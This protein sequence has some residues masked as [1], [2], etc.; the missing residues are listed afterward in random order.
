MKKPKHKQ[1]ICQWR[2]TALILFT[3]I[4]VFEASMAQN[5]V[6]VEIDAT[7]KIVKKKPPFD[8]P[9]VIK[10]K[11]PSKDRS[12]EKI[13]LYESFVRN[14]EKTPLDRKG[15][16]GRNLPI[17]RFEEK[18][19]VLYIYVEPIGPNVYLELV[20]IH[21]FTGKNLEKLLTIN[22]AI[23]SGNAGRI[24]RAK[25]SFDNLVADLDDESTYDD[26]PISA[27]GAN[28]WTD[29]NFWQDYK[30]FYNAKLKSFYDKTS[31]HNYDTAR[32]NLDIARL[33]GLAKGAKNSNMTS[34]ALDQFSALTRDGK[35]LDLIKGTQSFD[36]SSYAKKIDEFDFAGRIN[37]L[38]NSID[39]LQSLIVFCEGYYLISNNV[40]RNTIKPIIDDLNAILKKMKANSVFLKTTQTAIV[41]EIHKENNLRFAEAFILDNQFADLATES[42]FRVIPDFGIANIW[43]NGNESNEAYQRFY[44]GIN[45][46]PRPVNKQIK[47]REYKDANLWRRWSFSLGV[48]TSSLPE[49]EFED[50]YKSVSL[51]AG[52]NFRVLR[53]LYI[54]SGTVLLRRKDPNPIITD[55]SVIMAPYV[56]VSFDV[57]I[58]KALSSITGKFL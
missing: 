30:T 23:A 46:S 14:G 57:D 33:T 6:V 53:G 56:G 18:D 49:G 17:S 55:T 47:F 48:T 28:G 42:G 39:S 7:S 58:N 29:G 50:L 12:I 27:F 26:L 1:L 52:I 54:S 10:I 4:S 51:L 16:L 5:E 15:A 31:A 32:V 43:V 21:K 37:R 2:M 8:Q 13:F 36:P 11:R 45:I 3:L 44:Y 34:K 22:S 9:F 24:A 19:D 41:K 38:G 35:V 40:I 20:I 25:I